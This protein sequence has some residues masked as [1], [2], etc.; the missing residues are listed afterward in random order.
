MTNLKISDQPDE[1]G[2]HL[3]FYRIEI[4]KKTGQRET[5]PSPYNAQ[6]ELGIEVAADNP[7]LQ[8]LTVDLRSR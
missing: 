5:I 1:S 4:S 6:T 3:G 7:N 2:V 8:G